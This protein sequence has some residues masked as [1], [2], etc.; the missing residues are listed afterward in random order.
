MVPISTQPTP[1]LD[2]GQDN[3]C[4]QFPHRWA[5]VPQPGWLLLC[6]CWLIDGSLFKGLHVSIVRFYDY[7]PYQLLVTSLREKKLGRDERHHGE[8]IA[9]EGSKI[10]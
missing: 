10:N 9:E 3:L 4:A 2:K 6:Q 1:P 5:P 8:V 7:V